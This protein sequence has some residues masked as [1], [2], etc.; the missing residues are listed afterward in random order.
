MIWEDGDPKEYKIIPNPNPNPKK[1]FNVLI[2]KNLPI[3][4]FDDEQL[5][6]PLDGYRLYKTK[7]GW[8]VFYTSIYTNKLFETLDFMES[9]G[10]DSR[11]VKYSKE[12]GFYVARV[13]PKNNKNNFVFAVTKF[14]HQHGK[15][16]P[17]WDECINIHDKLTKAFSN[18]PL[19]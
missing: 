19:A 9:L 5:G 6:H 4:D 17:Q 2:T 13:E 14:M 11:Y 10:A 3:G 7:N 12:R 18:L 8:R 16:L 15:I 1:I